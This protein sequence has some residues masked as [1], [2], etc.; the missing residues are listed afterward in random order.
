MRAC[1]CC[2][3]VSLLARSV[4]AACYLVLLQINILMQFNMSVPF[5]SISQT[6]I[7]FNIASFKSVVQLEAFI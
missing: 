5:K 3:E 1:E 6:Q 4:A 2:D 7:N